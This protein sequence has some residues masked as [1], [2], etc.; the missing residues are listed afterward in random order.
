MEASAS[1][2]VAARAYESVQPQLLIRERP[3]M[4]ISLMIVAHLHC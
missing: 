1:H 2:C 3:V 4:A